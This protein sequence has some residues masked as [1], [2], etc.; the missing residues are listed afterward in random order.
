[1]TAEP[2]TIQNAVLQRG[3]ASCLRWHVV[4][5]WSSG[6]LNELEESADF[7]R[8]IRSI[9]RVFRR[10]LKFFFLF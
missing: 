3:K 4:S 8:S 2:G 7:E 9:N 10:L 1:M 5:V 6:D